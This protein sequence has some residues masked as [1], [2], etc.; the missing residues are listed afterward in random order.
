MS[1]FSIASGSQAQA[2]YVSRS[3]PPP[4][5]FECREDKPSGRGSRAPFPG[6]ASLR[7]SLPGSDSLFLLGDGPC[8]TRCRDGKMTRCRGGKIPTP[9]LGLNKPLEGLARKSLLFAFTAQFPEGMR[10][11]RLSGQGRER[12]L[13]KCKLGHPGIHVFP[14]CLPRQST[15]S[16]FFLQCSGWPVRNSLAGRGTHSYCIPSFISV[17]SDATRPKSAAR[18]STTFHGGVALRRRLRIRASR[19]ATWPRCT[20]A[21]SM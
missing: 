18:S 10:P 9:E 12:S 16:A 8:R 17:T 13:G 7:R 15:R 4:I 2:R 19:R 5:R 11:M 14:E 20:E 3:V 21:P 1:F 6:D